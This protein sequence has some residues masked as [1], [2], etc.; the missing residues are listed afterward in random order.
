VSSV[1]SLISG[2]STMVFFYVLYRVFTSKVPLPDNYWGDGA[3][4]LE[5]AVPSPAP[6]HTFEDV[7]VIR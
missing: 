7:P 1:G 5:W 3:T 2:A 4:T 6:H